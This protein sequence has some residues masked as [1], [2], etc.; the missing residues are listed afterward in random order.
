MSRFGF[1]T[2]ASFFALCLA[3]LAFTAPAALAQTADYSIFA[4]FTDNTAGAEPLGNLVQ[5]PDGNFYGESSYITNDIETVEGVIYRVSPT[6]TLSAFYSPQNAGLGSGSLIVGGD[7]Y[8]YGLV[9]SGGANGYGYIFKISPGGALTTLYNFKDQTDGG[10]P[11]G[12]LLQGS[13][14]NFYGEASQGGNLST[15]P[16]FFGTYSGCGTIFK[17]TPAG[18]Y[19]VL[20]TFQG[21]TADY[22][23][24]NYGLVQGLDGNYYGVTP[25]TVFRITPAGVLTTIGVSDGT[26]DGIYFNG[27]LVEGSDGAFYGTA[28]YNG[29]NAYGTVFK[30]TVAG[31]ISVV[32]ALCG[33]NCPEGANPVTPLFQAGDGN[34]YGTTFYGNSS[35]PCEGFGCGGVFSGHHC[36]QAHCALQRQRCQRRGHRIRSYPGA[37][38][39]RR[40]LRRCGPW[41]HRLG[42]G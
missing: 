22:G 24:P 26:T 6:G 12:Q 4:S 8:F 31:G 9:G 25:E 36:G 37:G 2:L 21:T 41:R 32:D 15:C 5:A 10:Y 42:P 35:G 34:F 28:Q 17:L 29:A 1:R 19:S 16:N 30:A 27:P 39:R 40:P 18:A 38:Q 33:G 20:Y 7:G 3:V 13:D 23:G 14:G 11:S